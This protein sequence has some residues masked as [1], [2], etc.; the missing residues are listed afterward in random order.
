MSGLKNKEEIRF[1]TLK[2][3]SVPIVTG[4]FLL[5]ASQ[6]SMGFSVSGVLDALKG[7][8]GSET[9][10][11]DRLSV[12]T[13]QTAITPKIVGGSMEE[14]AKVTMATFLAENQAHRIREVYEGMT[15]GK[16]LPATLQC[17]VTAERVQM[18]SII[19]MASD[20][21]AKD[22]LQLASEYSDPKNTRH[23]NRVFNHLT[24]F[25]DVSE[26]SAGVCVPPATGMAG[27]DSNYAVIS[28]N[29]LLTAD[30]QEAAFA[31]IR[32][33]IDPSD[34]KVEDCTTHAC[35]STS[36]VT[37]AYKGLSSMVQGAYIRQINDS[38]QHDY[39]KFGRSTNI[40]ADTEGKVVDGS[41][42]DTDANPNTPISQTTD[43]QAPTTPDAPPTNTTPPAS[44]TTPAATDP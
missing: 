34:N 43:K 10:I 22:S 15:V 1:K 28:G 20:N 42:N 23:S 25:C 36:N 31:Y 29:D 24:K 38:L 11:L 30:E 3:I 39:G 27:M 6:S 44:S 7:F 37:S 4:M 14:S 19:D 41:S 35:M 13:S 12:S 16:G 33:V 17:D 2:R 8:A 26:A 21:A 5:T 9:T 40:K 18:T 32:N